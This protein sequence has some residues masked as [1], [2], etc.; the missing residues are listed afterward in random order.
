[1]IRFVAIASTTRGA[2]EPGEVLDQEDQQLALARLEHDGIWE[3]NESVVWYGQQPVVIVG[4]FSAKKLPGCSRRPPVP[5]H[6][7]RSMCGQWID[8]S[9]VDAS[10][11]VT[12][13]AD[14]MRVGSRKT[15]L[16]RTN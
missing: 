4:S 3:M 10:L 8:G 5:T 14:G 13:K 7:L 12:M 9:D 6:V 15:A 1:M 16:K 2:I 11:E